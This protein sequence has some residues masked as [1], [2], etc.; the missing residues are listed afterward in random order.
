LKLSRAILNKQ[1]SKQRIK[2]MPRKA[3]GILPGLGIRFAVI[4]ISLGINV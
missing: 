1:S 4:A 2:N 3:N